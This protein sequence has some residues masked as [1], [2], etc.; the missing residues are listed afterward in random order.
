MTH[1]SF[2]FALLAIA[3]VWVHGAFAIC[4]NGHPSLEQEYENSSVVFV[5]RVISKESTS[6][7][8]NYLDGITYSVS[9]QEILRGASARTFRLF[10]EN[11]S[12]RFPMRVSATYLVFAYEALG[13]LT[14]DNC[15]NSGELSEKAELLS[16]LRKMKSRELNKAP[17]QRP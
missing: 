9:V 14:V 8:K 4:V 2:R 10:S 1:N 17:S 7:S 16:V 12:G 15:G 13:R 5:G 11:S 3:L 6:E